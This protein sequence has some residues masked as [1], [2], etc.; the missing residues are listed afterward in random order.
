MSLQR[1]VSYVFSTELDSIIWAFIK[2]QRTH[3]IVLPHLTA[4]STSCTV[5]DDVKNLKCHFKE[6]HNMFFFLIY[7]SSSYKKHQS[8]SS[9][10]GIE[11]K[12]KYENK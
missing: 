5:P 7:P 1:V 11:S 8:T 12:N 3:T 10:H 6:L 2:L 9:S 4:S